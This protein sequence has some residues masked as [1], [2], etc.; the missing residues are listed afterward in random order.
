MLLRII[1]VFQLRKLMTWTTYLFW[2]NYVYS[3]HVYEASNFSLTSS[4]TFNTLIYWW[5]HN[6]N[7]AMKLFGNC[8]T[9][10]VVLRSIQIFLSKFIIRSTV[11]V[12]YIS[13]FV[14]W[15][16]LQRTHLGPT[17]ISIKFEPLIMILFYWSQKIFVCEH[18]Y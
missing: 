12:H 15:T 7:L 5:F 1:K 6:K 16:H 4:V 3:T 17:H 9:L 18:S 10:F 8:F 2:K 11:F 13:L 14:D